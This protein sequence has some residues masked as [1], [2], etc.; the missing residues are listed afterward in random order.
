VRRSCN[1]GCPCAPI[2]QEVAQ[3]AQERLQ[4][5]ED[6]IGTPGRLHEQ[7]QPFVELGVDYFLLDYT[8]SPT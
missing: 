6:F 2:E 3:I 5:S 8:V 7:M 4:S 1:G